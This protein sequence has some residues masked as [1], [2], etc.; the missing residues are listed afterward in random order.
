MWHIN[1][2]LSDRSDLIKSRH[3]SE[4][5]HT[6][7]F[8]NVKSAE[9]RQALALL[10]RGHRMRQERQKRPFGPGEDAVAAPDE[11]E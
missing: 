4:E 7:T 10:G 9:C 1:M 11:P 5:D 2:P 6:G 3:E 8:E